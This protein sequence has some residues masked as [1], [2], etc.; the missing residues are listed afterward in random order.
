MLQRNDYLIT[1]HF[2]PNA[3]IGPRKP[4]VATGQQYGVRTQMLSV[5]GVL[6]TVRWSSAGCA[7]S[8][9]S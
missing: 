1:D 9:C 7:K 6:V 8:P 4:P 5:R 2:R 3:D